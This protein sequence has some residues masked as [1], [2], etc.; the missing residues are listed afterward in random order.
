MPPEEARATRGINAR[1]GLPNNMR[2][3]AIKAPLAGRQKVYWSSAKHTRKGLSRHPHKPTP[4][5]GGGGAVCKAE[6]QT[7]PLVDRA[8]DINLQVPRDGVGLIPVFPHSLV[9]QVPNMTLYADL[10]CRR[11]LSGCGVFLP[12]PLTTRNVV[13]PRDPTPSRVG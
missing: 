10:V 9:G 2:V 1:K 6:N 5:K 4:P 11:W 3:G 7:R 13:H 8:P 12:L